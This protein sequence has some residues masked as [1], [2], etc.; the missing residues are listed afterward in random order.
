MALQSKC[1]VFHPRIASFAQVSCAQQFLQSSKREVNFE[2]V[3]R[4]ASTPREILGRI[5]TGFGVR[6]RLF[7]RADTRPPGSTPPQPQC[8]LFRLGKEEG[9][10]ERERSF[11]YC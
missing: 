6:K 4:V 10:T 2:T 7:P 3:P 5:R 8:L 11:D 1:V 9:R